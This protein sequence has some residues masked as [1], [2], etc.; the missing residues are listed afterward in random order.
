MGWSTWWC[1]RTRVGCPNMVAERIDDLFFASDRHLSIDGSHRDKVKAQRCSNGVR[2][3]V[4]ALLR[5]TKRD[6]IFL[7]AIFCL[8][9]ALRVLL[10]LTSPPP[11]TAWVDGWIGDEDIYLNAAQGVLAVA[12]SGADLAQVVY[13]L[14]ERGPVYPLY[15][16]LIYG[17]FG[18]SHLAV[19]IMQAL[20]DAAGCILIYLV[21]KQVVDRVVGILSAGIAIF[22]TPFILSSGR[23]LRETLA[24]FLLLLVVLFFTR[25][26]VSSSAKMFLLSG[27]SLGLTLLCNSAAQY[28]AVFLLVV[29]LLVS[30]KRR[31][32]NTVTR[33]VFAFLIGPAILVGSWM[34]IT[35]FTIGEPLMSATASMDEKTGGFL[36]NIFSDGW[37]DDGYPRSG[38]F[39]RTANELLEGRELT[40][41]ERRE[42][43]RE[44]AGFRLQVA[45]NI[46]AGNPSPD[47]AIIPVKNF[48][49]LWQYPYNTFLQAFVLSYRQQ[50]LFHRAIVLLGLIGIPLSLA[51]DWRRSA[52]IMATLAYFSLIWM[53]TKVE[54]RYNM[55]LMPYV[56]VMAALALHCLIVSA[57]KMRGDV[58]R[59]AAVA[60]SGVSLGLCSLW[61]IASPQMLLSAFATMSALSAH[62]FSALLG[63]LLLISLVPLLYLVV[64][65]SLDARRSCFI[66][67]FP[68]LVLLLGYNLHVFTTETWHVWRTRLSNPAQRIH[69]EI[70][71]PDDFELSRFVGGSIVIDML[72][73][74]RKSYDL[75]IEVNEQQIQHY[76]GGLRVDADEFDFHH[77]FYNQLMKAQNREPEDL[78]QWFEM[79]VDLSLLADT[80]RV[81]VDVYLT[82]D[83]EGRDS[84]VDLYGDY[85]SGSGR[86][87]EG[88][89]FALARSETSLYKYLFD[90]DFRLVS[91]TPLE[92]PY[93]SSAF[94]DGSTWSHTDL[95]PEI[96]VQSGEFRI[97]VKL[98]RQD[99][100]VAIL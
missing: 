54:A 57:R 5:G 55:A 12:R 35:A 86:V 4:S 70:L 6:F 29:M 1:E 61:L 82:G 46:V 32:R 76:E 73:G 22:Y 84:Y 53:A 18:S 85:A 98:L 89:S 69:Q 21:G 48:F 28:L 9:A 91:R 93:S 88:P 68:I 64:K 80:D 38:A 3:E 2:Q 66:S 95:S 50:V 51:L 81:T 47:L 25:A 94:Y 71:L 43:V 58:C 11:P 77:R 30:V 33:H 44:S 23:L 14:A 63:N 78:R 39:R 37:M 56:I 60:S 75:I 31:P 79:P 20:L 36:N 45:A 99:G 83:S 62:Y 96:G 41:E 24:S 72:G 65:A 74:A 7:L 27:V 97:R 26:V 49:R 10:V 15:L 19:G 16:A 13:Q 40:P 100:T 17:V 92:S 87:F 34:T 59:R 8:A 42:L 67:L 90:D 52:A